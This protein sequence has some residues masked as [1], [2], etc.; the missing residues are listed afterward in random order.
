LS[1]ADHSQADSPE[2][3]YM[4]AKITNISSKVQL[5]NPMTYVH[6]D[7]PPILI[8]HGCNDHLVPVQQSIIFVDKLKEYVPADRF[9]FDIL[10]NADHGDP[11]FE[12]EENMNRV[13]SFLVKRLKRSA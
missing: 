5:A 4:G 9:E 2:S 11:L 7:T 10:E 1:L 3:R 6:E 8:Q 13:F 12:T